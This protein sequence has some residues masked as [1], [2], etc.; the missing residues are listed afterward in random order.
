MSVEDPLR[1]RVCSIPDKAEIE[2]YHLTNEVIVLGGDKGSVGWVD[3]W[4]GI[5]LCDVLSE[6]P[7]AP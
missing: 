1:D 4:R 3:L 5:L 6:T 2:V 7:H